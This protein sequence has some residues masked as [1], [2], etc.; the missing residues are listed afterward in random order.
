MSET[1]DSSTGT[2]Y[3][4]KRSPWAWVAFVVVTAGL[5]VG[6][7]FAALTAAALSVMVTPSGGFNSSM[8]AGPDA[9][10]GVA[11]FG[12]TCATVTAI[13]GAVVAVRTG[14]TL[15]CGYPY[16]IGIYFFTAVVLL[17]AG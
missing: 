16:S 14:R 9:I 13:G 3:R 11:I 2:E 6:G 7:A 8:D 10:L 12:C 1:E 4:A 5:T 17:L 15:W